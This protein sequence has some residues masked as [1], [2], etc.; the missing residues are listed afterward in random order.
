M[1]Y[2]L[3][4]LRKSERERK[5]ALIPDP[6]TVQDHLHTQRKGR[7]ARSSLVIGTLLVITL[8]SGLWFGI[9]YAQKTPGQRERLNQ[10]VHESQAQNLTQ[11]Q[12]ENISQARTDE[13]QHIPV[14]EVTITGNS[15]QDIT[16]PRE[17][18]KGIKHTEQ[19]STETEQ[20]GMKASPADALSGPKPEKE[21][22]PPD[23][24][25]L[26]GLEELPASLR[27]KLPDLRF[28]VF[29]YSDDPA[30]RIVRVNGLTMKEGQYVS[31]GLKLEQII[32]DGA[33]FSYMNYRFRIGIQ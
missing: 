15:S 3:D 32:P 2:I 26:Y 31:D 7:V 5:R 19:K 25:K 30:S 23:T 14:K 24:N 4:A 22:P 18:K 16:N 1:S 10:A 28:S 13:R 33:I 6:L 20:E 8:V 27:Q 17:H 9:W 12:T 21:I 11:S 29:L